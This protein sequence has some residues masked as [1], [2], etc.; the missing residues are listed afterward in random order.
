MA[1]AVEKRDLA[2]L[3]ARMGALA[4][5]TPTYEKIARYLEG[6]HM[7]VLFMTAAAMAA[8]VGVSQGSV[9]R[10][11]A[12]LGYKG[13]NDFLQALQKMVGKEIT[14]PQRLEYFAGDKNSEHVRSILQMEQENINSLPRV[15]AQPAYQELVDKI[16]KAQRVVL[17]SARMSATLLPYVAYVLGKIRGDV[18]QLTPGQ[19]SW[20]ILPLAEAKNTLV[21]AVAFPRYPRALVE[22]LEELKAAGFDIAAVTDSA[23]SPLASFGKP[24]LVVPIT[25]SSIF[26]IYSTPLLFF[27]LLLR[28]VAKN[29]KGLAKRLAR[30]E[31]LE[32]AARCYYKKFD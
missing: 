12:A 17:L 1:E 20:D 14:A 24:C 32:T 31:E 2:G 19:L 21:L 28:D 29:T 23:M 26:D 7:K 18:V 22:K 11:C 5:E 10:F 6:N 30:L 25:V 13:F 3:L 4:G 27:N 16:A 15:L 8:E 9:S